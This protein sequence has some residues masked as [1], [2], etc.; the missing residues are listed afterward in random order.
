MDVSSNP[1]NQP[2]VIDPLYILTQDL[3]L[4]KLTLRRN[5][6]VMKAAAIAAVPQAESGQNLLNI[7]Q[8]DQSAGM[9]LFSPNSEASSLENTATLSPLEDGSPLDAVVDSASA[10]VAP[11]KKGFGRDLIELLKKSFPQEKT[12]LA[13]AENLVNKISQYAAEVGQCDSKQV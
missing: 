13:V 1:L 2:T 12:D 10:K 11:S 5:E 7:P 4:D 3:H 6:S 9:P 8:K